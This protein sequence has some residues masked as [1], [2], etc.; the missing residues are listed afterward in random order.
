MSNDGHAERLEIKDA[1]HALL[2]LKQDVL[3]FPPI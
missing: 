1:A 2:T 3:K